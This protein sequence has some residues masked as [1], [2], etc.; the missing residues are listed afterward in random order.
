MMRRTRE[1]AG[2]GLSGPAVIAKMPSSRPPE[3]RILA[4]RMEEEGRR[5]FEDKLLEESRIKQRNQFEKFTDTRIKEKAIKQKT[6]EYLEQENAALDARRAKLAAMLE[7]EE[8]AYIEEVLASVETPIERLAR[9]R[10]RVRSLKSKREAERQTL[11]LELTEQHWVSNCEP[12]R[13]AVKGTMHLQIDQDRKEQVLEKQELLKREKEVA[14]LYAS[15]WEADKLAKDERAEYESW[16]RKEINK[17]V[18][19]VQLSQVEENNM[20]KQA[21]LRAIEEEKAYRLEQD[22]IMREEDAVLARRA[23]EKKL[24]FKRVLDKD[25]SARE[26][27][28]MSMQK[29]SVDEDL[30][31]L[32]QIEQDRHDVIEQARLD[33]LR[34]AEDHKK[35][36]YYTANEKMTEQQMEQDTEAAIREEGER[37][38]QEQ[39]LKRR[40]I[41]EQR[42]LNTLACAQSH[43]EMMKYRGLEHQ[44]ARALV[45]TEKQQSDMEVLA[46]VRLEEDLAFKKQQRAKRLQGEL[47][48]QMSGKDVAK[49]Q[50]RQDRLEAEKKILDANKAEMEKTAMTITGIKAGTLKLSTLR[51]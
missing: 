3:Y 49:E 16:Y 14:G 1:V 2:P 23:A 51:R 43:V 7:V 33:K 50:E 48:E 9:M 42:K 44:T 47:V 22:L 17:S 18:Q 30:K 27:R 31:V 28:A 19:S 10:E 45:I 6:N 11:A 26:T 12:L 24:K 4:R 21:E 38:I 8:A 13:T 34:R 40:A 20:A 36:L 32:D 39:L 5:V 15:C 25:A 41:I 29:D 35:F 37:V 46:T